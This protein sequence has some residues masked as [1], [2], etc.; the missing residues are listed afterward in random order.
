[1][2]EFC[3]G[4]NRGLGKKRRSGIGGAAEMG[5]EALHKGIDEGGHGPVLV[6]HI[7]A[8]SGVRRYIC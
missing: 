7:F 4:Q 3:G 1:M 6:T 8:R 2:T 5:V